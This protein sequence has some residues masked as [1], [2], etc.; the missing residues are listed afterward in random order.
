MIFNILGIA[1]FRL[2][3]APPFDI[4]SSQPESADECR[5]AAAHGVLL[6]EA[7]RAALL[8]PFQLRWWDRIAAEHHDR[9]LDR[10]LRVSGD[11]RAFA[12]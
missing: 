5:G 8:A 1:F 12:N 11:E 6:W 7:R 10:P 3:F 4:A 9:G 2:R